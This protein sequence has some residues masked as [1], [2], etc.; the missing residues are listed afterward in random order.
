MRLNSN[1]PFFRENKNIRYTRSCTPME[2][3]DKETQNI[4]VEIISDT[5]S[6]KNEAINMPPKPKYTRQQVVAALMK[7]KRKNILAN[8]LKA[9]HDSNVDSVKK[10]K[11]LKEMREKMSAKKQAERALRKEQDEKKRE[12]IIAKK[13]KI[14]S[15]TNRSYNNQIYKKIPDVHTV[16]DNLWQQRQTE[17]TNTLCVSGSIPDRLQT[18]GASLK[19]PNLQLRSEPIIPVGGALYKLHEKVE[20]NVNNTWLVG[21]VT[22][23]IN[24]NSPMGFLSY[25]VLLENGNEIDDVKPYFLRKHHSHLAPL[26]Q[27]V[28]LPVK[29][30]V[31]DDAFS[32]CNI[33]P[34]IPV[35]ALQNVQNNSNTNNTNGGNADVVNMTAVLTKVLSEVFEN[36]IPDVQS[37]LGK[38]QMEFESKKQFVNK[39]ELIFL[40]FENDCFRPVFAPSCD[41][42]PLLQWY[43]DCDLIF[44]IEEPKL[45]FPETITENEL[46][47]FIY[48][49]INCKYKKEY[50]DSYLP[51]ALNLALCS[52]SVK[53]MHKRMFDGD[54]KNVSLPEVKK[55]P[56][57]AD[58]GIEIADNLKNA[59]I[60]K[61]VKK[62]LKPK[63]KSQEI[64]G[65]GF[66]IQNQLNVS[67]QY[68]DEV[69][70]QTGRDP[71]KNIAEDVQKNEVVPYNAEDVNWLQPLFGSTS[72]SLETPV[73]YEIEVPVVE[74]TVKDNIVVIFNEM[75]LQTL[76]LAN[77]TEEQDNFLEKYPEFGFRKLFTYETNNKKIVDYLQESFHKCNFNSI[78]EINTTL[79]HVSQFIE[80]TAEQTNTLEKEEKTVKSFL[81]SNFT[82]DTDLNHKMKASTL[83]DLILGSKECKIEEKNA[84]GFKN[85]LS[86]YLKEMG[87]QKKRYN[88]GFYYYGIVKNEVKQPARI[89][90][91]ETFGNTYPQTHSTAYTG[92]SFVK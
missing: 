67:S 81:N 12:E 24:E 66:F 22:G 73:L 42:A 28:D 70:N 63:I 82:F 58:L 86:R 62:E 44:E 60:P 59:A 27:Q 88:D 52:E 56:D 51:Q 90:E 23:Y 35:K 7:L 34:Y 45:S 38:I 50:L 76:L 85:R 71:S 3:S 17:Y 16:V 55:C 92:Y 77:P 61:P 68:I 46:Q 48:K 36:K 43:Q 75:F 79:Q 10:G 39:R 80:I 49:D 18:V 69:K 30:P 47:N 91:F 9:I 8:N 2:Q 40:N 87:L 31:N 5:S 41:L 11:E 15:L 78:E 29:S 54:S 20:V 89:A 1:F 26:C 72:L 13:Q 32:F 19:I 84:S 65:H 21:N 25:N 57:L 6:D 33:K 53:Q 14:Q 37:L 64:F 83:F 4:T 74:T